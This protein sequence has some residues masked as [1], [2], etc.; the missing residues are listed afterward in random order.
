[1]PHRL[2]LFGLMFLFQVNNFPIVFL[3]LKETLRLVFLN[4]LVISLVC[5]P[6]YVNLA[7][8]FVSF[9]PCVLVHHLFD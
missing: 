2:N 8:L 6:T 5:L 9:L 7:I 4:N 1:M 3:V